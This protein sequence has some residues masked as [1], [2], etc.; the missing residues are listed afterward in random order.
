MSALKY[1][2]AVLGVVLVG[3]LFV[4][5]LTASQ[6]QAGQMATAANAFLAGLTPEQ[7]QQAAL[8]FE[9]EERLR[10]NF[11]PNEMFPRKGLTIKAMTEAQRTQAHALLKT[12]LSQRGYMT[13]TSIMELENV[14]QV[15]EAPYGHDCF[16][17]EE[18]RQTPM[19]RRFLAH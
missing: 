8:P 11:I 19:I 10:W 17:L 9:G 1:S 14:L 16:L 5:T 2:R 4:A 13:A 12:G 15:I 3:A 18:A 6:R 7:R